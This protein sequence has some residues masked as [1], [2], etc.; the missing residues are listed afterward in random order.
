MM[1]YPELIGGT[2]R[3]DTLMMQ[4]GRGKFVSKIGAEGVWLCGVLPS[5]EWKKGLGI[6]LKIEDGDDKR[7]RAVVSIE[8]LRQLG[9][10]DAE[11]LQEFSPMLI[12]NRRDDV[13]GRVEA[14]FEIF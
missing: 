4:I 14:S 1:S 11:T 2:E 8:V 9:I 12:R 3:L 10:F 7:A 13:V 5:P 6:A